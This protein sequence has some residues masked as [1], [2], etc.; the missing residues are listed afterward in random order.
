MYIY[1]ALTFRWYITQTPGLKLTLKLSVDRAEEVG[2]MDH[3]PDLVA[4]DQ[5]L[6]QGSDIMAAHLPEI[7]EVIYQ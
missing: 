5:P 3:L 6:D 2:P 4:S 1:T 7:R